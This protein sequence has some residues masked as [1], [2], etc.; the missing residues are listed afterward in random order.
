[1]QEIQIYTKP[2]P[3]KIYKVVTGDNVPEEFQELIFD[4][5]DGDEN[6][7]IKAWEDFVHS[8]EGD[9]E[10]VKIAKEL[11]KYMKVYKIDLITGAGI[12]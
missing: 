5:I 12:Y 3:T 1:M 4:V 9:E 10:Q 11:I 7:S 6:Y 2:K 8:H